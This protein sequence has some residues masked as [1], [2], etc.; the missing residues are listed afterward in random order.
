MAAF[1]EVRTYPEDE[2]ELND[3][4][5]IVKGY[6]VVEPNEAFRIFD[7]VVDQINDYVQADASDGFIL[8]P[9][10]TPDGLNPFVDTVVPILQEWG[11]HRTEYT[12]A[13]LR[14]HLGLAVPE[15]GRT[16]QRVAS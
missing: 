3:L 13:T 4:M 12:G 10:V 14:D 8:V 16:A 7:S 2:D 6:A 11:V 15:R 9:H 1:L 5:E